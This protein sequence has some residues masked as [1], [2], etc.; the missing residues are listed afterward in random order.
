MNFFSKK[1]I[2]FSLIFLFLLFSISIKRGGFATQGLPSQLQVLIP[3][4]LIFF[5]ENFEYSDEKLSFNESFKQK[6]LILIIDESVSYEY[7]IKAKKKKDDEYFKYL[8]K[9]YSI[10]NCS[11]QAVFS[12]MNGIKVN[13]DNIVLRKNLWLRA[14]EANYK[15]LYFSAQEKP[16]N[17]QYLQTINELNHI[18]EKYFFSHFDEKDRD[19]VLLEKLIDVSSKKENQFIVIIKNG[20]HFPYFNKF[21][22]KKFNLNKNS[23][24]NLVYTYS[25]VE[26]SI[27]F[28]KT[29]ISKFEKNSDIIYLSD[30]GQYL[31][32]KKL[33]HCNSENPEI[34]EWEIPLLYFRNKI[35]EPV[36]IKS[37][38]N[39]Y[40]FIITRM[41]FR[42][43]L[44]QRKK[45]KLFYG[46]FNKRLNRQ[47]KFKTVE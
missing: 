38:L 26:N 3:L 32:N 30:H 14:K 10:H 17:Y 8:K 15:T 6:N 23:D 1:K 19:S 21:D 22:L 34:E 28:L 42:T 5:S 27:N 2:Y 9:F 45:N 18:D 4:P 46:N 33:S 29:L 7:F 25:I 39:L 41:G 11:A 16:R 43:E 37:N 12:L 47:I 31:E 35:N 24:K 40:D 36:N 44:S 20:S 13:Q